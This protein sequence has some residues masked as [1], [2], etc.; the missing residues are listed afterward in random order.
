MLIADWSLFGVSLDIFLRGLDL[1]RLGLSGID[2][3]WV[4][5]HEAFI[6]SVEGLFVG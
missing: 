5:E 2:T 4:Q 1:E 3:C 6:A